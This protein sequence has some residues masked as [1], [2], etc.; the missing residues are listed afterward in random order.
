MCHTPDRTDWGSSASSGRPKLYSGGPVNLGATFDGIEERSIHFKVMVHRIHTGGREGAASLE[1]IEPYV[2]YGYGRTPYF[3]DEAIFPND[4]RN[5]TVCHD[6][7]TYLVD[8]IPAGAFPT[9]ANERPVIWHTSGTAAHVA[10][11]P[12]VPPIQAAC[13]G[14]HATGAT[15]A[16]VSSKT[17][18]GVETCAQCHS[19]GSVSVD[20]VHGL[21][22]PSG[23]V[24]STFSSIVQGIFVPRCATAACHSGPPPQPAPQLDADAAYAALV[25]VQSTESSFKLVDPGAPER[26]YLV[27]KLRGDIAAVGG[28]GSAMPSGDSPLDD[29]DIRAIEAWIANGAPND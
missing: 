12:S 10:G 3:F 5:C 16:H 19:K 11:E 1:G 22:P 20:V 28:S 8:A 4:L 7:K 23:G 9:V 24:G 25:G 29:S 13:T 27:Y 18:G 14:C 6:G 15:F 26:S 17:V 21:A 2:I